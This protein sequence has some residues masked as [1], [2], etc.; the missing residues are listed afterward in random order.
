M[1]QWIPAQC[2]LI[3]RQV[4]P[5]LNMPKEKWS[6]LHVEIN[7]TLRS[8]NLHISPSERLCVCV[9]VHKSADMKIYYKAS[10]RHK[11]VSDFLT[12]NLQ[13]ISITFSCSA[14]KTQILSTKPEAK[15]AE[16]SLI[17]YHTHYYK[18]PYNQSTQKASQDETKCL[19]ISKVAP[20]SSSWCVSLFFALFL[21]LSQTH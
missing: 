2:K 4:D 13:R 12:Q 11:Q 8:S 18:S 5:F 21:T 17:K 15:A 6:P 10:C 7:S 1:C 19:T 3:R 14:T 9:C 20:H 16:A